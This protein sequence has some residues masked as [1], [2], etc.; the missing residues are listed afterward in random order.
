MAKQV[1]NK[2][3][4]E[5]SIAVTLQYHHQMEIKKK[6]NSFTELLPLPEG[7]DAPIVRADLAKLLNMSG[8]VLPENFFYGFEDTKPRP[9]LQSMIL[10]R[11]QNEIKIN[12]WLGFKQQQHFNLLLNPFLILKLAIKKA[13]TLGIKPYK[14]LSIDTVNNMF[15]FTFPVKRNI[16]ECY[17]EALKTGKQLFDEVID[18]VKQEIKSSE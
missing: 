13:K 6:I 9:Y 4:K 8:T 18:E 14:E 11:K 12:C 7:F 5:K 15:T 17:L 1:K 2:A 3:V 16:A 10:S